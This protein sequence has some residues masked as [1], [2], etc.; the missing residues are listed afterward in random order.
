LLSSAFDQIRHYSK[1]DIAVSLR[2]LRG[3]GD[4][5]MC[6]PD[7]AIH[8]ALVELGLRVVAGCEGHVDEQDLKAL[9]QRLATLEESSPPAP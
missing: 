8:R 2:L 5:A 1:G 6:T 7:P 4:I 9:Y 3:L